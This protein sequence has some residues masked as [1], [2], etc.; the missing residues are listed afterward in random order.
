MAMTHPAIGY[1]SP[2]D[3]TRAPRESIVYVAGLYE[4]TGEERPDFLAVVDVDPNSKS[5]SQITHRTDMPNVGDELHHY[6]WQ[7]CSSACHAENRERKHLVVP[8]L[9]SS[10]IHVID[11]GTDPSAP[12]IVKV[13]E[14]EEVKAKTGLSAPHTVHCMP[15]DNVVMS[16]LGNEEGRLGAGF[17]VLDAQSFEIKGRWESDG[18]PEWGY[19]FWYQPRKNTLISSE[20]AAPEVFLPG[21]NLEDVAAGKYGHS[22]HF[23]DL[24]ARR[25]TQTIDLGESGMIPLEIRWLHDPDAET[26]FVGAALSS[27]MWRFYKNGDAWAAD[28]V[29]EV[30]PRDLETFPVPV[31]GLITDLVVSMDDRFLYFSNWLHGDLRQYDI[32]D[33]A[34]PRLTDSVLLGVFSRRPCTRMAAL[35]WR[36]ADVATL[37]G[38]TPAVCDQLAVFHLGQPVLSRAELV[39]GADRHRRGRLDGHQP[40][41]LRG[42]LGAPRQA[43]GT[44]DAPSRGDVT[45]EIFQ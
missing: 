27:T 29:I 44:R 25:V 30:D 15:G 6:G 18:A 37:H 14:P 7:I 36:S 16:M 40:G 4:G 5:Y 10:R 8:G 9:R 41:L 26:G 22:L 11:V 45:T 35:E 38:R 17:L 42:L 13:I 33:P 3:A 43:P 1:E 28:K 12:K 2:A 31:P 20:W 24:E 19:D 34:H 21:F 32:S 39:D 23:W